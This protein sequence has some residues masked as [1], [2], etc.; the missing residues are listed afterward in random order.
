MHTLPLLPYEKDALEP[1]ISAETI[2]Y[3]YGKHHKTYVDKLN[4]LLEESP[5]K[6]LSLEELIKQAEGPVF[7]NAAQVW[8]HT[9]YWHCLTPN[10]NTKPS[11]SLDEAIQS[12]FGSMEA[13]K[14][15]FCDHALNNFG[16]GWTWLVMDKQKKLKIVN[17][18]NAATPIS[19]DTWMPILTCD[20]WEHAYYIDSRNNRAQYLENYWELINWAFVN[21]QFEKACL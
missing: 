18:S 6:S 13:L 2:E 20:V 21:E 8:N 17:T 15:D 9:F 1:L 4:A 7:N 5:L 11:E 10:K 16:S 3:H 19:E 14:K 12:S